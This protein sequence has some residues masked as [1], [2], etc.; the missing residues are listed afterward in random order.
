LFL[1]DQYGRGLKWANQQFERHADVPQGKYVYHL[2]DD[3]YMYDLG[4]VAHLKRF[5]HNA[6]EPDVILVRSQRKRDLLPPPE[7]WEMGWEHGERP[8]FWIGSGYCFV[9]KRELWQA[10]VWRYYQGQDEAWYSGGD[11]HFMSGLAQLNINISRLDVR[12]GS[13]ERAR[14]EF[15]NR[16]GDWLDMFS[17]SQ[18]IQLGEDVWRL[19]P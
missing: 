2:D 3:G 8:A 15:E 5:A 16:N 1:V 18:Y 14:C 17:D 7:V 9:V 6:D 19:R 12:A 13:G 4:F 11:W 10:N